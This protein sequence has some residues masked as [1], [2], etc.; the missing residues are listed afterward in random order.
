RILDKQVIVTN[1]LIDDLHFY[2]EVDK[3]SNMADGVE[4]LAAR[5]IQSDTQVSF[6]KKKLDVISDLFLD[7]NMSPKLRVRPWAPP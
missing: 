2:L 7:S 1:F 3:F 6:L 4:A 5:K